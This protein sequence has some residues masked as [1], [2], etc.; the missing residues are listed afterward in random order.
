MTPDHTPNSYMA[1]AVRCLTDP[2]E[3]VFVM[4]QEQQDLEPHKDLREEILRRSLAAADADP[5]PGLSDEEL[6]EHLDRLLAEP[7]R[8]PAVWRQRSAT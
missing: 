1:K 3:A 2:G 8:E 5:S 6:K 7:R 4:L